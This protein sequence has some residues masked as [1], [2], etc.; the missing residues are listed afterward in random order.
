M[1]ARRGPPRLPQPP[2]PS[3]PPR[4]PCQ[5]GRRLPPA[6]LCAAVR[7]GPARAGGTVPG[8]NGRRRPA[9][10]L[11]RRP[12]APGRRGRGAH[13]RRRWRRRARARARGLRGRQSGSDWGSPLAGRPRL[14]RGRQA[15]GER[16]AGPGPSGLRSS[17]RRPRSAAHL[18]AERGRGPAGLG[19][20]ERGGKW[21]A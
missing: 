5:A 15:S 3:P 18:G 21:N 8:A 4:R 11:P 6:S 9:P 2:T 14:A 7:A 1:G 13:A 10:P 12:Q 17:A 19:R 16:T 20:G